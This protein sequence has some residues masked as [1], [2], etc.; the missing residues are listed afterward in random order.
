MGYYT[1]QPCE[2]D[3]K[4][5]YKFIGSIDDIKNIDKNKEYSVGDII[6]TEADQG[7][8]V[9]TSNGK[10]EPLEV[11]TTHNNG[12]TDYSSTL[13]MKPHPTNCENC[14]AVLRDYKC[15]YCGTEYPRY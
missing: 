10:F 9:Y 2:I 5:S 15:E 13:K 7:T 6:F 14:G 1:L 4:T 3:Y 11:E 12:Y 8:Y